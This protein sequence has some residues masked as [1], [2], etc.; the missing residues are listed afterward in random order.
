MPSSRLD[1]TLGAD[2]LA[3]YDSDDHVLLG[4]FP[5]R[6]DPLAESVAA[7]N[8]CFDRLEQAL[9]TRVEDD[10]SDRDVLLRLAV[11]PP[12]CEVRLLDLP[13]LR[14]DEIERVLRRDSSRYF[15]AGGRSLTVGGVRIDTGGARKG[16]TGPIL[17]AAVPTS[18]LDDV[19]TA[20]RARGWEIER[21]IPAHAA[22][23]DALEELKPSGRSK[24][25]TAPRLLVASFDDTLHILVISADGDVQVRRF[26]TN[27]PE[28]FMEIVEGTPGLALVL[29]PSRDRAALSEA[30]RTSGWTVSRDGESLDAREGAARGAAE[31]LPEIVPPSIARKR[32]TEERGFTSRVLVAAALLLILATG[33]YYWGAA[34]AYAAVRAER[35]EIRAE[36][37]PSLATRDSLDRL[38][39]R[40]DEMADLGGGTSGWTAFLVELSVLLPPETHLQSLR[41]VGDTVVI[42]G[43]GGRAGEALE[44]L[45]AT[46]LLHDVQ[47]EGPI[48]REL[49]GGSTARERFTVSA[50]R[51]SEAAGGSATPSPSNANPAPGAP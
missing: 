46:P 49:E 26:P 30:I 11:L 51:A 4:F 6:L 27:D 22:W 39:T 10:P 41:A 34:R 47:L 19:D 17:A 14:D 29:A 2:G 13:G 36:V 35:E 40:L 42:E 50:I 7:L 43:A 12:L 25:R 38:L 9:A 1:I 45:R 44:A 28:A 5:G 31:A 48:Q 32:M 15:L 20:V 24:L 33:V 18:L 37:A 3:A 8:T 23:L 21:I 16:T